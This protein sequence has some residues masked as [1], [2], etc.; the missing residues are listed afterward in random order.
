MSAGRPLSDGVGVARMTKRRVLLVNTPLPGIAMR[1][2][3]TDD[4][5]PVALLNLLTETIEN[6]RYPLS[7]R[8]RRLRASWRS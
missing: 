8:I 5:K 4:E 7:P 2:D 3:P 6:A 1:L